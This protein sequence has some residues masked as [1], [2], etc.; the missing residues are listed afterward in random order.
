MS[1]PYRT[2]TGE[3]CR[4][5]HLRPWNCTND[6]CTQ[7]ARLPRCARCD[8]PMVLL[9]GQFDP[10]H[11]NLTPGLWRCRRCR[12]LTVTGVLPSWMRATPLSE[13]AMRELRGEN[14][15]VTEDSER[16]RE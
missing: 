8:E 2:A 9:S 16:R 12:G 10:R 13:E 11:P 7:R 14:D 15:P 4:K 6:A 5:G 1:G 3:D